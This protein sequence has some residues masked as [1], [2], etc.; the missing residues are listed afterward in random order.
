MYRNETNLRFLQDAFW[1]ERIL[2][3]RELEEDKIRKRMDVLKIKAHGP[4]YCV[5]IFAPYLMNKDA[6]IIDDLLNKLLEQIQGVYKRLNIESYM[7]SDEYCNVVGVFSFENESDYYELN[8]IT[9]S[10]TKK[11][12]DKH[13]LEMFVGVGKMVDQISLLGKSK[14]S[15]TGALAYKFTFSQ[16]HV[17]ISKDVQR[18]YNDVSLELKKYYDRV[19]GCFYDGNLKLLSIRFHEL[20]TEV[21][22][23]SSEGLNR[24]KNVCIELTATVL[25]VIREMGIKHAPELDGIYT[26]IAQI[27]S[28]MEIE[29]WFVAYCNSMLQKI[30]GFRQSKTQIL[31]EQAEEFIG[32]NIQNHDLDIR[33]ISE[34]VGL[35][36]AYFSELFYREKGIHINEYIGRR[37]VEEAKRL[38]WTTN[39]KVV[40]ISE[41]VGF[42][43]PNYFNNVFKRFVGMTP[44][45]YRETKSL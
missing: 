12:M 26:H 28:V 7:I 25:R 10:I 29:E 37:R 43:S 19:L 45:Q 18:Y 24:I 40:Q 36:T 39:D 42:S 11:M 41:K 30:E 15:A 16:E 3:V 5:V 32:V 23:N 34:Y 38:L 35:T 13:K 33:M 14:D 4:F 2:G 27:E 44:K 6:E 20:C 1:R 21:I 8:Q 17:I 31:V 22:D 9:R